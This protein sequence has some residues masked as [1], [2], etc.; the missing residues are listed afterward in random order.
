MPPE[1]RDAYLL[2]VV[3]QSCTVQAERHSSSSP[4]AYAYPTLSRLFHPILVY[5]FFD[6]PNAQPNHPFPFSS[7]F[8][9]F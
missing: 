1:R 7:A 6:P 3:E 8:S 4:R 9:I 5:S 2:Q